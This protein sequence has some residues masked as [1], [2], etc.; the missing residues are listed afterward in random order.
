MWFLQCPSV[1]IRTGVK[2]IIEVI[3]SLIVVAEC[4]WRPFNELSSRDSEPIQFSSTSADNSLSPWISLY[5]ESI[6]HHGIAKVRY[7]MLWANIA[8]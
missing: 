1:D 5:Y 8:N 2:T 7:M 6:T 4:W 3:C